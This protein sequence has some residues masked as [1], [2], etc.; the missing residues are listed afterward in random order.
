MLSVTG[1]RVNPVG[2]IGGVVITNLVE[3]VSSTTLTSIS[4]LKPHVL[5]N[6][7]ED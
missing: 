7:K 4:N 6:L 1:V 5:P 2:A 3:S